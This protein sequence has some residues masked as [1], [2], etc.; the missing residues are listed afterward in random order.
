MGSLDGERSVRESV[1]RDL[2]QKSA[3]CPLNG[4]N[5][6]SVQ[7]GSVSDGREDELSLT[8]EPSSVPSLL[9]AISLKLFTSYY[10]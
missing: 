4:K 2:P 7:R 1:N 10:P 6:H 3:D 8:T 9:Q 5:E